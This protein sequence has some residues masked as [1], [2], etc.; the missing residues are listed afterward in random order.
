MAGCTD[1]GCSNGASIALD[2]PTGSWAPGAYTVQVTGNGTAVNCTLNVPVAATNDVFGTC[3]P[4]P[5]LGAPASLSLEFATHCMTIDA[6]DP[7]VTGVQCTPILGQSSLQ[8]G[9]SGAPAN[10]T[11]VVER[12][13][14]QLASESVALHYKAFFP[15]GQACGGACQQASAK[16][17]V[18]G[19]GSGSMG[20]DDGGTDGTGG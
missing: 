10:V 6:G 8:L 19:A 13:G 5:S 18:A 12:G 2:S 17:T 4:S 9:V 11:V 15:N 1:I 14:V 16:F 7:G 20:P 3:T